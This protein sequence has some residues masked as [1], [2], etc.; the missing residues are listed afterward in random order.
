MGKGD[1]PDCVVG[2]VLELTWTGV[3]EEE[4][5]DGPTHQCINCGTFFVE[6]SD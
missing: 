5:E 3:P 1:C 6:S 4:P 2:M